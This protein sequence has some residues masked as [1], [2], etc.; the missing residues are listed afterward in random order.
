MTSLWS[1]SVRAP[2]SLAR[3][4]SAL[5]EHPCTPRSGELLS[6]LPRFENSIRVKEEVYQ[7][8]RVYSPPSTSSHASPTSMRRL[9]SP[10]RPMRSFSRQ[11]IDQPALITRGRSAT[12]S[13]FSRPSSGENS[14][15]APPAGRQTRR[16]SYFWSGP[17]TTSI[18]S[19][20]RSCLSDPELDRSGGEGDERVS[21]LPPL[22][23]HGAAGCKSLGDYFLSNPISRR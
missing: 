1:L 10:I 8:P 17:R 7:M 4:W 12:I 13:T 16:A 23:P 22:S 20:P 5:E 15:P 9:S 11:E 18:A 2:A 21:R 19:P 3:D 6:P 14:F